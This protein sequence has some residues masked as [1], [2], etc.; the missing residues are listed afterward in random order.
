MR[1]VP[2]W[3]Y[4][5]TIRCSRPFMRYGSTRMS[6]RSQSHRSSASADTT[7]GPSSKR[8]SVGLKMTAVAT[9][10]DDNNAVLITHDAEAT[11]RRKFTF[12]RHVFLGCHQLDAVGLLE[13]HVEEMVREI[14]CH[15][16]GVFKVLRGGVKYYP[17]RYET[18]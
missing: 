13:D 2:G 1:N 16:M 17:P 18:D 5:F 7:S 9:Y 3:P 4:N 12:G 11:R 6:M 10:A 15:Q 14:E 8:V